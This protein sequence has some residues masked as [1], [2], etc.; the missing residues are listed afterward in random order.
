[1]QQIQHWPDM[2]ELALPEPVA[3]DLYRQL[4]LPFDSKDEAKKI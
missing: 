4:L 3:Q 2:V 1:M